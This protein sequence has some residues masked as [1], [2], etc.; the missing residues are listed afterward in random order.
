MVALKVAD[1]ELFVK[2]IDD[3]TD[4]VVF[5][6]NRKE[7]ENWFDDWRAGTRIQFL[8]AHVDLGNIHMAK[9]QETYLNELVP[10]YIDDYLV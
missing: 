8:K 2:C 3:T 7:A 9:G 10:Y 1:K 6:D 4:E 5:T